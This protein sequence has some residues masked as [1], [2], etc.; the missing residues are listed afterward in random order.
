LLR[1][2]CSTS[3]ERNERA[4]LARADVPKVKVVLT[5]GYPLTTL[6]AEQG[7]LHEFA[8][9]HRPYRLADLAKALRASWVVV[10]WASSG[11]R[12]AHSGLEDPS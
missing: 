1:V 4:R 8:F 10:H 12:I 6:R 7:T 5:S 3:P 9:V 11:G 2:I